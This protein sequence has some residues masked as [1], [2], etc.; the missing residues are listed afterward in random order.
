MELMVAGDEIQGDDV[1]QYMAGVAFEGE[2]PAAA[3][4]FLLGI[5]INSWPRF[6]PWLKT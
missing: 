3:V 2:Q 5:K 4:K 6:R 1:F